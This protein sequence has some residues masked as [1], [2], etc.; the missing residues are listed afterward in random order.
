VNAEWISESISAVQTLINQSVDWFGST[1]YNC[2][3][4]IITAVVPFLW[5]RLIDLTTLLLWAAGM[6]V[7][8][9]IDFSCATL[10]AMALLRSHVMAYVD[11]NF[12]Y[13]PLA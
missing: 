9:L 11:A 7:L 8:A 1:V 6:L 13:V 2:C 3:Y 5:L 4:F 10:E 12:V